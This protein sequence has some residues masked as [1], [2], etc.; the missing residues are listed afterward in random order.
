[1]HCVI[2]GHEIVV[3]GAT[4]TW[5]SM[6]LVLERG[7]GGV[8]GRGPYFDGHGPKR[9]SMFCTFPISAFSSLILEDYFF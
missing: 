7:G 9:G 3:Y 5:G 6:D 4:S 8:H 2:K 1:M